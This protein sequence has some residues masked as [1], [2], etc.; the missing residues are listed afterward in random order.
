M[1]T[2]MDASKMK[3]NILLIKVQM[4][5]IIIYINIKYVYLYFMFVYT[6]SYSQCL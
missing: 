5:N 4:K 1:N 6:L 2:C 3:H